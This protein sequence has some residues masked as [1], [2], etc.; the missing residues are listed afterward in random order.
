MVSLSRTNNSEK[1]YAKDGYGSDMKTEDQVTGC[2]LDD[3][4]ATVFSDPV[5]GCELDS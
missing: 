4:D 3:E 1:T 2:E 5:T